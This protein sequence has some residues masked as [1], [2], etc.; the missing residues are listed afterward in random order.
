M[1]KSVD[2]T[3]DDKSPYENYLEDEDLQSQ[4]YD[5]SS[6]QAKKRKIS[7]NYR[8]ARARGGVNA[9]LPN[10]LELEKLKN[11]KKIKDYASVSTT[12]STVDKKIL[13]SKN[14][15]Q[16]PAIDLSYNKHSA[17]SN[18][19]SISNSDSFYA[20]PT[21]YFGGKTPMSNSKYS[22]RVGQ[23]K[24]NKE[25]LSKETLAKYDK[26]IIILLEKMFV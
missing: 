23:K 3:R 10:S 8:F 12:M 11:L 2:P 13:D 25:L 15:F 4:S 16:S 17:S 24:K 21:N 5:S 22:I 19:Q 6:S 7:K 26:S 18:H 20:S 14:Q 1:N 9:S